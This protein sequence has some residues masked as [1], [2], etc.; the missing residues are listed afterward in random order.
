LFGPNWEPISKSKVKDFAGDGTPLEK[1]LYGLKQSSHFGYGTY[2]NLMILIRF[3]AS[4][5]DGGLF[6]C[7]D[8]STVVAAV[9]LYVDDL[10]IIANA[11]MIGKIKEKMQKRFQI[12]HLGC[13]SCYVGMNNDHNQEHHRID[14]H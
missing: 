8:Q 10:L 14:I 6:M 12:H 11:G 1:L 7:E 4:C 9:V 3:V 2:K 5:V 13:I